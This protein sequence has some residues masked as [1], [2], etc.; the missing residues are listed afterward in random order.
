M[1]PPIDACVTSSIV[2]NLLVRQ[3]V[4]F[5]PM[6]AIVAVAKI[7]LIK[8]LRCRQQ[9]KHLQQEALRVM[10]KMV[11]LAMKQIHVCVTLI[12]VRKVLVKM[13]VDNG[14]V[15]ALVVVAHL[16]PV[17]MIQITYIQQIVEK[18]RVAVG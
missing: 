18:L 12:S 15:V 5:G 2:M 10:I 7:S 1:E 9:H 3:L 8:L 17:Q 11:F 6:V 14:R 16:S 13:P 4:E